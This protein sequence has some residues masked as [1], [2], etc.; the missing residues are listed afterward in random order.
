MKRTLLLIP[1]LVLMTLVSCQKELEPAQSGSEAEASEQTSVL[2]ASIDVTKTVLD[3][4]IV[5]WQEGDKVVVTDGTATSTYT[6]VPE[7]D[8]PTNATLSTNA[9]THPSADAAKLYAVYPAE[10]NAVSSE[11]FTV[12][13][14]AEQD[15]GTFNMPMTGT[16]SN[17]ALAFRNTVSILRITPDL[18]ADSYDG[19]RV[20]RVVVTAEQDIACTL[21]L[22]VDGNEISRTDGTK[23]VTL[24]CAGGVEFNKALDVAVAPG[25]YTNVTIEVFSNGTGSQKFTC[26]EINC[27]LNTIHPVNPTVNN[28]AIYESANCYLVKKP[29]TY[30]FPA[31]VKGNGV[32]VSGEETSLSPNDVSYRLITYR[33]KTAQ[34]IAQTGTGSDGYFYGEFKK[35]KLENGWVVITIPEGSPQFNSRINARDAAKNTIWSWHIWYNPDVEDVKAG[36]YTFLNMNLG[37]SQTRDEIGTFCYEN[38]GMQYQWGRKD[39]FHPLVKR[40]E[41]NYD[42]PLSGWVK[43]NFKPGQASIEESIANPT[44]FYGG[45]IPSDDYDE[46]NKR[47]YVRR[48]WC[49]SDIQNL[50]GNGTASTEDNNQKE[51]LKTMYDPCPPGYCVPSYKVLITDLKSSMTF[52]SDNS[53]KIGE[54]VIAPEGYRYAGKLT[55]RLTDAEFNALTKANYAL[56]G[57]YPNYV[58][59]YT[60]T[61]RYSH[62]AKI[63]KGGA[64]TTNPDSMHEKCGGFPIRPIK[65]SAGK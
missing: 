62:S 28:L 45:F 17:G 23:S 20:S 19:V 54:M 53:L 38:A 46:N 36:S 25:K 39:P 15:Y 5:K 22:D 29:G 58:E 47:A 8:D 4:V 10:G 41:T 14:P 13:V 3:G 43:Y 33:G 55:S 37:A 49:S 60:S 27:R 34:E 61:A 65:Q 48:N 1:T 9:T 11:G 56:V 57:E 30:K 18:F 31:N 12:N 35:C 51:T 26:A 52:Q 6:A 2:T 24:L 40:D 32:A 64:S 44:I 63:L 7:V 21:S 16:G 42:R 50:W 59:L